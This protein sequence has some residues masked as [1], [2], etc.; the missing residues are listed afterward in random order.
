MMT[1]LSLK[2]L[3]QGRYHLSTSPGCPA[4]AFGVLFSLQGALLP[5]SLLAQRAAAYLLHSARSGPPSH[6]TSPKLPIS[7]TA[8][9][10]GVLKLS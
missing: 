4:H 2:P 1:L 9:L 6:S 5:F 3:A 7:L 10:C 8:L